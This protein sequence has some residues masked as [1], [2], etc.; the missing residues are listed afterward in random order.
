MAV[1]EAG[2]GDEG[3]FA[4]NVRSGRWSLGIKSAGRTGGRGDV[5][6]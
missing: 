6:M 4:A 2:G 3:K 5:E 1:L